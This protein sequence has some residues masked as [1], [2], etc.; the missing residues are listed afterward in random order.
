[1]DT[2]DVS[3]DACTLV[4]KL[5][6]VILPTFV[7]K[8]R[9]HGTDGG[10]SPPDMED[11]VVCCGQP[12]RDGIQLGSVVGLGAITVLHRY[13]HR[14]SDLGRSFGTLRMG[15]GCRG[16]GTEASGSAT[17]LFVS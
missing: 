14:P 12:K 7:T 9:P 16:H 10:K 11:T 2:H 3:G 5:M 4:F 15:T 8:A 6:A 17:D 1:L 13:T